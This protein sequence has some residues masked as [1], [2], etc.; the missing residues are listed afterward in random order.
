MWKLNRNEAQRQ[1][2]RYL[3]D[4][5]NDEVGLNLDDPDVKLKKVWQTRQMKKVWQEEQAGEDDEGE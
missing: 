3:V 1:T 4:V 2:G 5:T